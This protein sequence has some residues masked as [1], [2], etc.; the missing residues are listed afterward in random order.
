MNTTIADYG[1]RDIGSVAT[2]GGTKLRS[3]SH[4]WA[5]GR[6]LGRG[7]GDKSEREWLAKVGEKAGEVARR[8]RTPVQR[9]RRQE[10]LSRRIWMLA[11]RTGSTASAGMRS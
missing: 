1:K 2:Q 3:E 7:P 8:E 9:R 6:R 5:G 11:R 10:V 4:W